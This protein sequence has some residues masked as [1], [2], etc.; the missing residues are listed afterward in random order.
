MSESHKKVNEIL[1]EEFS[2]D[3]KK[4]Y[5]RNEKKTETIKQN[6]AHKI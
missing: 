4:N 2:L 1:E 6:R 5:Q 3:E